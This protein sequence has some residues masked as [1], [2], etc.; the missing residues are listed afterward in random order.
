MIVYCTHKNERA[1]V[2]WVAKRSCVL[3]GWDS[4]WVQKSEGPGARMLFSL[5]VRMLDRPN[6]G[7]RDSRLTDNVLAVSSVIEKQVDAY[8]LWSAKVSFSHAWKK[9]G[10]FLYVTS[11]NKRKWFSWLPQRTKRQIHWHHGQ[12][13]A[14]WSRPGRLWSR[15]L[16]EVYTRSVMRPH[17]QGNGD[18]ISFESLWSSICFRGIGLDP[19][20]SWFLT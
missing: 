19:W 11:I 7:T 16:G 2:F 1:F 5:V 3:W 6:F 8:G 15:H 4:S 10:N 18:W 12:A 20:D 13:L 9:P 17:F 14:P